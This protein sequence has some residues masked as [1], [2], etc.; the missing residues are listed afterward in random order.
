MLKKI[1]VVILVLGVVLGCGGGVE[2]T[3]VIEPTVSELTAGFSA[4]GHVRSYLRD[5]AVDGSLGADG[6]NCLRWVER[7]E[8]DWKAVRE[9]GERYRVTV[10][11][12]AWYYYPGTG[13]VEPQ[14]ARC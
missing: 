9:E 3:V 2:P 5:R 10:R 6:L 4:I 1:V 12:L 13:L 11:D 14:G 7:G 8:K